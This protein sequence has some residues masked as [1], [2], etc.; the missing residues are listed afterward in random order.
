M[1][2]GVPT[3]SPV[4]VFVAAPGSSDC[5]LDAHEKNIVGLEIA[6][7]DAGL[8]RRAERIGGL[9][10]D[11]DRLSERKA[12][13]ADARLERLAREPLHHDEAPPVGQRA[14]REDVDDVR[15]ANLIDGA[16]L[17]DEALD[18][19]RVGA[20]PAAHHLDRRLLADERMH[21]RIHRR[22]AAL[23]DAALDAVIAEHRAWRQLLGAI[24]AHV[25]NQGI[26]TD[27]HRHDIRNRCAGVRL[28]VTCARRRR[29]PKLRISPGSPLLHE[30]Y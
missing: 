14:E 17:G 7:N 27:R 4:F 20:E 19:G 3:K 9:E 12:P 18:G 23:T 15:M 26:F 11:R 8:V 5:S 25:V 10:Q 24:F 30:S 16:R 13:A 22:H 2:V 28:R 21:G 29:H 1:C 6:M